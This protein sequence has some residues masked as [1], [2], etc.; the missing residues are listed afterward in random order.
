MISQ[1]S[2]EMKSKT[3]AL[4]GLLVALAALGVLAI[5]ASADELGS[6]WPCG[7]RD[8]IAMA[9]VETSAIGRELAETGRMLDAIRSVFAHPHLAAAEGA[10]LL[11]QLCSRP[12]QPRVWPRYG[13]DGGS[14]LHGR[15]YSAG[16]GGY[17]SASEP[18]HQE[19]PMQLEPVNGR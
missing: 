8:A 12:N 14:A 6:Q 11:D 17:A 13:T 4:L 3:L 15:E 10:A 16:P 5:S 19:R 2:V 1:R 9:N 18:E 7:T